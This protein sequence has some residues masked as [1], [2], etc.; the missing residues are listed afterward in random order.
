MK[1]FKKS[2]IILGIVF[3]LGLVGCNQEAPKSEPSN[4]SQ[5]KE[6]EVKSMKGDELDK[7]MGDDKKKEDYMVVDVRSKDEYDEGHVKYAIN[8]SVDDLEG[9][10]DELENSKEKTVVTICN[11]GKKS[12][13]GAEILAKKGFKEVFNAE[14]VKEYSYK[15]IT[16]VENIQ[17]K[18]LE[19]IVEEGK[20]FIIDAREEK[21]FK[22]G[23]LKGAVNITVDNID[24]KMSEI[25][26]D[27]EIVTYCY[28]G[29]KSF[30][31]AQKLKDAGYK[32]VKNSLDGTKEYEFNLEEK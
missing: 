2:I 8:I 4:Q 6:V 5:E 15:N 10:I 14:G 32:D 9:R 25:P 24:E 26:K 18:A 7:I 31:I 28:S 1:R 23:H 3:S 21:D 16:K 20:A 30:V 29:N 19:K 22:K 13:K 12:Q 27:K 11:T 17:A